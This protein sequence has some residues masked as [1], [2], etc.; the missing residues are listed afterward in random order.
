[1]LSS[2]FKVLNF[3][4]SGYTAKNQCVYA[5]NITK[6]GQLRRRAKFQSKNK[7]SA[8]STRLTAYC[9]SKPRRSF[10]VSEKKNLK[11][12]LEKKLFS[13]KIRLD[14]VLLANIR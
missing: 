14:V 2:L 1:M 6:I 10:F 3:A 13:C 7:I 4:I 11:K 8:G 5:F 9:F 12:S